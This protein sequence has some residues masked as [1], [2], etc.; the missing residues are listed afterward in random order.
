MID[1]ITLIGAITRDDS[2]GSNSQY[3]L[4]I[5]YIPSLCKSQQNI[6]CC[7]S[8]FP[9]SM[10][11]VTRYAGD[12]KKQRR[13]CGNRRKLPWDQRWVC[14][15]ISKLQQGSVIR[16]VDNAVR[17]INLYP[18][19]RAVCIVNTYLPDSDLSGG[20]RYPLFKQLALVLNLILLL[21]DCL[22]ALW[23]SD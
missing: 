14:I 15:F 3:I 7:V 6:M 18:V 16:R 4:H 10:L 1:R 12:W 22:E 19:E 20:Y 5:K 13:S 23:P 8:E 2:W 17:W 11:N 9:L 21:W